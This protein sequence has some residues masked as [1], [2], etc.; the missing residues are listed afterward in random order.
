MVRGPCYPKALLQK[1]T[2]VSPEQRR[3]LQ[4]VINDFG[5]QCCATAQG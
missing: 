5:K 1:N 2:F 3:T 4:K